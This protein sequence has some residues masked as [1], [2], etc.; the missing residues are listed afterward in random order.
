MTFQDTLDKVMDLEISDVIGKYLT[1]KRHGNSYTGICPFHADSNPSLSINQNKGNFFKC[2]TCDAKGNAINFVE[3]HE[4]ISRRDAIIKL[5]KDHNIKLPDDKE[6]DTQY[7]ETTKEREEILLVNQVAN[8]YYT[9]TLLQLWERAKA[10]I[11]PIDYLNY[12]R[13]ENH[14]PNHHE[15]TKAQ[16]RTKLTDDVFVYLYLRRRFKQL[17]YIKD[18]SIGFAPSGFDNLRDY[19]Q[20]KSYKR[21]VVTKTGLVSDKGYDL[22]GNRIIYPIHNATNNIVGFA[23]RT[24]SAITEHNP[25]FVNTPET[26]VYHKKDILYNLNRAIKAISK[27]GKVYVVEGYQDAIA[28]SATGIENVVAKCS[29]NM[30]VEQCKLIKRYTENVVLF[31]DADAAGLKGTATDGERLL[32]AGIMPAILPLLDYH[33]PDDYFKHNTS[34][35]FDEYQKENIIDYI[36]WRA[37]GVF[38]D[39]IPLNEVKQGMAKIAKLLVLLNDNDRNF[40]IGKLVKLSGAQKA[41][42]NAKL[43]ELTNEH[44]ILEP[45]KKLIQEEGTIVFDNSKEN[46]ERHNFYS[47]AKDATGQIKGIEIDLLKYIEI[48]RNKLNFFRYTSITAVLSFSFALL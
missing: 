16:Y 6:I 12:M 23:G 9:D 40:Y 44:K 39:D 3:R 29:A 25:K 18:F 20:A 2:F 14:K 11:V 24:V 34:K 22:L 10:A 30:T 33:D 47:L 41:D 35:T 13:W 4:K 45:R 42:W 26:L 28:M 31:A 21:E 5:A 8:E 38:E 19:L 7:I 27:K 15:L 1:L 43:K 32:E 37:E 17:E 48:L 46:F 36:M